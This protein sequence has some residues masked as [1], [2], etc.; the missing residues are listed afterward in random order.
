MASIQSMFYLYLYSSSII[1]LLFHSAFLASKNEHSFQSIFI[2]ILY[3]SCMVILLFLCQKKVFCVQ[4]SKIICKYCGF[5]LHGNYTLPDVQ[6]LWSY[7]CEAQ[8]SAGLVE[9]HVLPFAKITSFWDNMFLTSKMRKMGSFFVLFVLFFSEENTRR[10][11]NQNGRIEKKNWR[12]TNCHF[13]F[14]KF[15]FPLNSKGASFHQKGHEQKHITINNEV[16]K[17]N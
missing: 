15:K 4:I 5:T 1:L 17:R 10:L 3:C 14:L 9:M 16:V 2:L 12:A 7:D 11:L 8:M 13:F 6:F